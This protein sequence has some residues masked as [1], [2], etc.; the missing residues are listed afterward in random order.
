MNV[1]PPLLPFLKPAHH[2]PQLADGRVDLEKVQEVAMTEP[3]YD[4][5][6]TLA[7]DEEEGAG[8]GGLLD[9]QVR[10][11][12]GKVAVGPGAA[13]TVAI[14]GMAAWRGD[15]ARVQ[16][17]LPWPDCL[18][19]A[20]CLYGGPRRRA[21][22]QADADGQGASALRL[23]WQSC[24]PAPQVQRT[25]KLL[26]YRC[27]RYFYVDGVAAA[28]AA[29]AGGPAPGPGGATFTP[30]P[31]LPKGFNEQLRSAAVTLATT[32]HAAAVEEAQEWD[33]GGR[34]LR[35]VRAVGDEQHL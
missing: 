28:A 10:T 19:R 4:S 7:A 17:E 3:H 31:A 35:C 6:P 16:I 1:D 13:A 12:G 27:T 15:C 18:P 22:P 30:V 21:C 33:L 25:H 23:M 26:E 5:V 2:G 29:V 8:R 14:D 9:W 20:K 24:V 32:G 34:Q 11:G